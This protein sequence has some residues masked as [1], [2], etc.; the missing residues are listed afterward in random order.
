MAEF[1]VMKIFLFLYMYYW[2]ETETQLNEIEN[3]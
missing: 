2:T 1:A 3:N